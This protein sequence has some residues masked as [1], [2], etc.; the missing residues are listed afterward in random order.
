MSFYVFERGGIGLFLPGPPPARSV[1]HHVLS[2]IHIYFGSLSTLYQVQKYIPACCNVPHARRRVSPCSKKQ[3]QTRSEGQNTFTET[4]N[5]VSQPITIN[6]KFTERQNRSHLSILRRPP[7]STRTSVCETE[8][9]HTLHSLAVGLFLPGPPPARSVT[10][11]VLS[12]IQ[13]VLVFGCGS[14]HCRPQRYPG[15]PLYSTPTSLYMAS[16]IVCGVLHP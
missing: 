2:H 14:V 15:Q 8:S 11:H 12:H 4:T 5:K 13:L 10:H 1:T 6:W 7:R 3:S 16:C 9:I